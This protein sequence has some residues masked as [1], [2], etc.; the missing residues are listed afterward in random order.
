MALNV[1]TEDCFVRLIEAEKPCDITLV[2]QYSVVLTAESVLLS[3]VPPELA[4]LPVTWITDADVP[5][6]I[7][8]IE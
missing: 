2:C 5:V 8:V 6:V 3:A 4:V 1:P 7:E